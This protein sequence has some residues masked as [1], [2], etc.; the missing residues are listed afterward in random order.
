MPCIFKRRRGMATT[1]KALVLSGGG[2]RGAYHI[3]V[4]EHL[5]ACGWMEDGEGPDIIAGTSIG[6]IN[7]AALA[8]GLKVAELKRR[9]LAMHTEEVHQLSSDLPAAARP[10]L[11]F[12][13]RS[14]LTS[15][16]HGGPRDSLPAEERAMS[17]TG[18]LSRLGKLFHA[19]PF[20]SLLE[21]T[22]WRH[23]LSGWMDFERINSPAAPAL[24][25]A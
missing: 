3:G 24:L 6:A 19:T 12:M 16:A 13:L 2:G 11:R 22:P 20:R 14:V 15:E 5:V 25:L 23:T 18:L 21:T 4:I 9:W 10:L 7:A 17:A 1:K 8:S